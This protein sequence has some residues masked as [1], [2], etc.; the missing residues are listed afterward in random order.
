MMMPYKA[1]R[2]LRC[3]LSCVKKAHRNPYSAALQLL[4]IKLKRLEGLW[5]FTTVDAEKGRT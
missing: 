5:G 4:L 3:F 2:V 1:T